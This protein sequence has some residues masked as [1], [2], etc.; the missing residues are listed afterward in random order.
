VHGRWHRCGH[1]VI[2]G[3][4]AAI[5]DWVF[6][7]WVLRRLYRVVAGE[8][9]AALPPGASVLDVG[10]GPGRLLL[11]LAQDR[12]DLH[13]VGVDPSEDMI[14][15]ARVHART[16]GLEDRIEFETV[17]AESLPFPA[18]TF[19]AVLS[20]L[21]AHHWTDTAAAITEQARVLRPG[22]Q[23]RVY[24]LR[25]EGLD[26]LA[27]VLAS[28]VGGTVQHRTRL[29]GMIGSRIGCLT[30]VKRAGPTG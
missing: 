23:Q 17:P 20:T 16:A 12:S 6:A 15:R 30:A 10:T 21:S 28:A 27:T 11:E 25:R 14:R 9:G 5:Y 19:D 18:D 29:A 26:D 1:G 4:P 3:R 22:G 24:D 2:R 13:L 7:R 8:L